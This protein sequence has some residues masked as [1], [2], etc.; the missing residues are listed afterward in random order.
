M[1]AIT[2]VG[3]RQYKVAKDEILL[4]PKAGK[5]K[6][7][8]LN[9]V[10]LIADSKDVTIGNPYIK[11]AKIVCEVLKDVKGPK[12]IAFKFR[13]RKN[14]QRS[15]GHRDLLTKVKIKEIIKGE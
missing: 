6:E 13:R 12:T 1:F 3:S 2:E 9:K 14:S 5:K 15:I 8:I 11:G 4:I 7:V 10:L